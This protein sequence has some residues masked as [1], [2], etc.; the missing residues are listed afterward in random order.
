MT[1]DVDFNVEKTVAVRNIAIEVKS[2]SL[3]ASYDVFHWRLNRLGG[4]RKRWGSF[5]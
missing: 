1:A 5:S 4:T 2:R 3:F